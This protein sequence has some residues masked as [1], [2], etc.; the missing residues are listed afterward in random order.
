MLLGDNDVD[1]TDWTCKI[2]KK[3]L[4]KAEDQGKVLKADYFHSSNQCLLWG[5]PS[6]A[7]GHTLHK[8][9]I[10][11]RVI[12]SGRGVPWDKITLQRQIIKKVST[13]LHWRKHKSPRDSWPRPSLHLMFKW[14]LEPEFTHVGMDWKICKS[15]L[16]QQ[17]T[18]GISPYIDITKQIKN[19]HKIVNMALFVIEKRWKQSKCPVEGTGG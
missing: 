9:R 10:H 11:C 18:E 14:A 3:I 6:T 7:Q 2:T 8:A 4:I 1:I 17:P 15:P 12:P 13:Q 16:V 19:M 5:N